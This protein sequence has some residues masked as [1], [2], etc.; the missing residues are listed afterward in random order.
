MP[1]KNDITG[2]SIISKTSTDAYRDSWERIFGMKQEKLGTKFE[3][4]L[5][6]NL[7]S[8]LE[9]DT[10]STDDHGDHPDGKQ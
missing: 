2:D 7:D 10:P 5:Y 6:D 1:A 9:T 8:L 4:V 3:E